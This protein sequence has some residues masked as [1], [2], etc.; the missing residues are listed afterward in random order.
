MRYFLPWM[1]EAQQTPFSQVAVAMSLR[2]CCVGYVRLLCVEVVYS[3]CVGV[4]SVGCGTLLAG[5]SDDLLD[6]ETTV[7]ESRRSS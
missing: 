6:D 5:L 3:C 7:G 1:S 4:G 2:V